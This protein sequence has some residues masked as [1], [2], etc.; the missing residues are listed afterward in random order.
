MITKSQNQI[1]AKLSEL[2]RELTRKE[3]NEYLGLSSATLHY[4]IIS[5][6]ARGL[7]EVRQSEGAGN[8]HLIKLK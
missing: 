1:L 7:I 6:E 2:N 8:S 4:A 5:L 3:L